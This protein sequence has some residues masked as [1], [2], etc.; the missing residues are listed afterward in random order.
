MELNRSENNQGS[1]FLGFS[2]KSSELKKPIQPYPQRLSL[3]R[4]TILGV[5]VSLIIICVIVIII[6]AAAGGKHK[7]DGG[8]VKPKPDPTPDKPKEPIFGFN[9]YTFDQQSLSNQPS[10]FS[11]TLLFH[12]NEQLSDSDTEIV[13]K[14]EQVVRN[15]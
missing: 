7:D 10:T 5:I 6:A 2:S 15:L 12:D 4:K 9:P 13:K 11:G 14:N 8:D 3:K 1:G